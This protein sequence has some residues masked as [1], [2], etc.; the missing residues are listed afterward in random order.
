MVDIV[1]GKM[2][3]IDLKPSPT[4]CSQ[5]VTHNNYIH[6]LVSF[7]VHVYAYGLILWW[8]LTICHGISE[9]KYDYLMLV[10]IYV[11]RAAFEGFTVSV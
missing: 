1:Y 7:R 3:F 6:F 5:V 9:L 11:R 2:S 8:S 10:R 4:D